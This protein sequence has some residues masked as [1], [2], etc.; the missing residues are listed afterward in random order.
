MSLFNKN[1][2]KMI[3][4]GISNTIDTIQKYSSKHAFSVAKIGNI[5]FKPY[6]A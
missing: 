1:G 2:L 4:L 3:L 5:V 6:T